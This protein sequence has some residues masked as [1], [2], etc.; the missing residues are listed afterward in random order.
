MLGKSKSVMHHIAQSDS[1][2][3]PDDSKQ[4]KIGSNEQSNPLNFEKFIPWV[5][6]E[7]GVSEIVAVQRVV[8][9]K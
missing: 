5:C 7:W 3:G 4:S 9:G 2:E 8:Q 6:V 1:S